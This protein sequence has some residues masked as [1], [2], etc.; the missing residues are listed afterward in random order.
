[1]AAWACADACVCFSAARARA[2]EPVPV[3][4]SLAALLAGQRVDQP[5][6]WALDS[7]TVLFPAQA[8]RLR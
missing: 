6:F 4:F 5:L 1:M 8:G 7:D 3:S 2:Q